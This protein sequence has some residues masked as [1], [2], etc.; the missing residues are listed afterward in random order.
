MRIVNAS[1]EVLSRP[2]R[3]RALQQIERAARTCY[4]SEDRITEDSSVRMVQ[5]LVKRQH[6]AMLEHVSA[7]VKFVCD[8]GVSHELV[9][10]RVASYAQEST[11]YCNYGHK[12][13][14]TVI[15]PLFFY[16][17]SPQYFLWR[18]AC[19][20]AETYYLQLLDNGATPQEARSVLPNSLKT[21]IVVTMNLREWMHF[22]NLRSIGTTG[23][24]HPQMR[25]I[26]DMA[27]ADFAEWLP[28]VFEKQYELRLERSSNDDKKAR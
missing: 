25:E 6:F 20:S 12:N 1:Y 28:E 26:A 4:K 14:I 18:A 21:E 8:R 19:Q 22:F 7:T 2:T 17:G 13:G 5:N 3:A 24:P 10:H 15:K 27:L 23:A 16:E 11:R 9:R